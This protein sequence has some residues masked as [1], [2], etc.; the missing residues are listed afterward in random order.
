[1]LIVQEQVYLGTRRERTKEITLEKVVH[2]G[3]VATATGT[4]HRS[5]AGVTGTSVDDDPERLA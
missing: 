5:Q 4:W 3:P 1:M 2:V